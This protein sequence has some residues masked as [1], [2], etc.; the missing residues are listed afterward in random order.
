[1]SAVQ[2]IEMNHIPL[3]YYELA[4]IPPFLFDEKTGDMRLTSSKSTLKS[5]LQI[6]ISSR[7]LTPSDA[8]VIDG[9]AFLLVVKWPCEGTVEDCIQHFLKHIDVYLCQLKLALYLI[10]ASKKA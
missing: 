7:T 1:M 9:F 5:K 8:F 4:A 3:L 10:N 6:E 2:E